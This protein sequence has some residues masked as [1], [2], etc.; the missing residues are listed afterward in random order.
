M[1]PP[2]PSA[3]SSPVEHA[4]W[5]ELF[6]IGSIGRIRSLKDFTCEIRRTGST[7]AIADSDDETYCSDI[8]S[9]TSE[10]IGEDAFSEVE[11][12][13]KACGGE[14]IYP[15]TVESGY[16]EFPEGKE[17]SIYIFLLLLS[18]FGKDAGP[19]G[20][21]GAKLFEDVCAEAG[22]AYFG[23]RHPHTQ[24]FVFGSPRSTG[25]PKRFDKA[26]DLL[27]RKMGEGRKFKNQYEGNYRHTKDSGLDIVIWRDFNDNRKGKLIAF[28]QCATGSNWKGKTGDLDVSEFC[29]CWL[30]TSP[31]VDPLKLI[32]VPHRVED[33]DW[34]RIALR[35]GLC[36]DRC[37]I[38]Y[39]ANNMDQGV[40]DRC[41]E[42]SQHA[43]S[44][45]L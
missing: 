44:E 34:C 6:T 5:F 11:W 31:V 9:E 22:K 8:H 18:V 45:R 20:M 26:V 37:R 21:S 16:L 7:D 13:L 15:F 38:A 12:R 17:S 40:I 27:C 23:E 33:N 41:A 14:A 1:Y 36:F 19:K 39:C 28:G 24:S 42:W 4:D 25:L 2:V 30:E 3:T 29:S 10:T 32:F 43:I 35:G